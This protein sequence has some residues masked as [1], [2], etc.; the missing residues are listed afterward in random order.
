MLAGLKRHWQRRRLRDPAWLGLFD[1]APPDECVSIDC[2]TTSLNVAEAELLSI[3]AVRVRGT[4]I[5]A[6][7][8]LYLLVRP[9]QLP[10]K[11]NIQ[12]HGLR[13]CEVSQGMEAR[14]AV[15]RLLQFIGSRPLLGYYLEYDVA[16]LNKYVRP[17]IGCGLP[18][19]QIE[20]SG[21]YYDYKLR[22]HPDAYIDL[23]LARLHEDLGV[24][25]LPRHD[26][27]NDAISVAMLYLALQARA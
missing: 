26:A 3:G 12:V 11:D 27:L 20:L 1:A 19:A 2:E 5:L 10:D 6:S 18:Q 15:T 9:Q 16:V 8:S 14:E 7:E 23:R 25:S 13:R 4:R 24:P 21:R 22:Q 17:L